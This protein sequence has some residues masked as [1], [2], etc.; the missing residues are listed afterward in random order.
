VS[1]RIA[2]SGWRTD[3]L[4]GIEKNIVASD[5]SP[6]LIIMQEGLMMCCSD[7]QVMFYY[8][9]AFRRT[10][11]RVVEC[12]KGLCSVFRKVEM[13]LFDGNA[14]DTLTNSG[15][16]ASGHCKIVEWNLT[17]GKKALSG[18]RRFGGSNA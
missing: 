10:V 17:D 14:G 8:V 3:K 4:I 16:F 18:F 9:K 1:N 13:V 15:L 5:S 7:H 11:V 6:A 2:S 12:D